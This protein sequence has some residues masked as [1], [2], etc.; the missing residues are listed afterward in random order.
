MVW[1]G[2]WKFH[3]QDPSIYPRNRDGCVDEMGVLKK[4]TK[5]EIIKQIRQWYG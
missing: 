1:D 5:N 4:I 2:L 3:I